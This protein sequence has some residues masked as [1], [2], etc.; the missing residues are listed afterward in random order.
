MDANV[1]V[2]SLRLQVPGYRPDQVDMWYTLDGTAPMYD[3]GVLFQEPVPLTRAVLGDRVQVRAAAYPRLYFASVE[4]RTC[5]S[6]SPA[7][8]RRCRRKRTST[9]IRHTFTEAVPCALCLAAQ[10][11]RRQR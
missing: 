7:P 10:S 11:R 1:T 8:P 6:I 4:T 5:T 2:H 9:S 3:A